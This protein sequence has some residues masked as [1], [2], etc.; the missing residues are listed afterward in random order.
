MWL[1]RGI[2]EDK[3]M[4]KIRYFDKLAVLGYVS[5]TIANL[6]TS[7]VARR[8]MPAPSQEDILDA[9]L[10]FI[11]LISLDSGKAALTESMA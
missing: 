11:V 3:L 5:L 6:D 7:A 4:Q 10:S 8:S 2:I 9:G 1:S